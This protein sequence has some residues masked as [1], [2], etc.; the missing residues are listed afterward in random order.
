MFTFADKTVSYA[1][2]SEIFFSCFGLFYLALYCHIVLFLVFPA[3]E[4]YASSSRIFLIRTCNRKQPHTYIHT[5]CIVYI[6]Y[7]LLTLSHSVF[8][9]FLDVMLHLFRLYNIMLRLPT[10]KLLHLHRAV[11]SEHPL[12]GLRVAM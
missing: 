4:S 2:P 7:I 5:Q 11:V 1:E 12:L 10:R 3:L 6:V 8:S 9:L